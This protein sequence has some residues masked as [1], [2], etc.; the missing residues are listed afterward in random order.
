MIGNSVFSEVCGDSLVDIVFRIAFGM[1][2]K[3][4]MSV[5]ICEHGFFGVVGWAF[6]Y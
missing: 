3:R 5:V 2:A 6:S 4:G 1:L